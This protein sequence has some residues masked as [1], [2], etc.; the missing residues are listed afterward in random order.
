MDLNQIMSNCL[1]VA[2]RYF[3]DLLA[4]LRVQHNLPD[5]ECAFMQQCWQTQKGNFITSFVNQHQRENIIES[6]IVDAM[7]QQFFPTAHNTFVQVMQQQQQQNS[8]FGGGGMFGGGG[9][10]VG[11][12]QQQAF[13]G[14]RMMGGM[15]MPNNQNMNPWAGQMQM[16][17]GWGAAVQQNTPLPAPTPVTVAQPSTS[18]VVCSTKESELTYEMPTEIKGST[19]TQGKDNHPLFITSTLYKKGDLIVNYSSV[20][21]R[22]MLHPSLEEVKR[23]VYSH[24][25]I[26]RGDKHFTVVSYL[27][28][29]KVDIPGASYT[30]ISTNIKKAADNATAK[31]M[32]HGALQLIIDVLESERHGPSEAYN[33]YLVDRFN[34]AVACGKLASEEH[35]AFKLKLSNLKDILVLLDPQSDNPTAKMI[36]ST[37]PDFS[38]IVDRIC[39]GLYE[40]LI[41]SGNLGKN[42]IKPTSGT[43]DKIQR[44]FSEFA[45]NE[46]GDYVQ[47]P[48]TLLALYTAMK[49][50]SSSGGT[51]ESALKA[52]SEFETCIENFALKHTLLAD[53]R[54]VIFTDLNPKDSG[55]QLDDSDRIIPGILRGAPNDLIAMFVYFFAN[56]RCVPPRHNFIPIE[57]FASSSSSID[58]KFAIGITA[59]KKPWVGP[60]D[61]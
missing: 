25:L 4:G 38:A 44:F 61:L 39:K 33:R 59:D 2:D 54:T 41:T 28:P 5:Q 29:I 3:P 26:A 16:Q 20:E 48:T 49:T 23:Q 9:N 10:M 60:I 21:F 30:D 18:K 51:T 40:G 1:Q 52:K 31:Q 47:N 43:I 34:R 8:G 42:I 11:F 55:L 45:E 17:S 50:V 12:G 19:K 22:G 58:W 56:E 46:E 35:P 53:P 6:M 36:H 14:N 24:P 57:V 32:E 13:G 37:I 27:T 15:M 7:K